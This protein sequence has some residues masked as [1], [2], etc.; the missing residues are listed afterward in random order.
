MYEYKMLRSCFVYF[1]FFATAL[2]TAFV[3][4]SVI[5]QHN[6]VPRI[7]RVGYI[8]SQSKR[9]MF[10]DMVNSLVIAT[11]DSDIANIPTNEFA[12][13][14]AGGIVVMFGGLFSALA[15]GFIIDKRNLYANIV[16]DSYAQGGND[17]EFWKGLSEEE[18][19]KTQELLLRLKE[20]K[21]NGSNTE[22]EKSEPVA[23]PL[24]TSVLQPQTTSSPGIIAK[25]ADSS[26]TGEKA[27]I[28]MFSDYG[29]D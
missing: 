8:T 7:T 14:F 10:P 16:A 12:T 26:P 2:V 29:N 4:C 23:A 28:G 25:S 9:H 13:V 1:L 17:E 11:I 22:A 5:N 27:V 18:K 21:E 3:P 15:V 19:K 20:S 6:E 24:S